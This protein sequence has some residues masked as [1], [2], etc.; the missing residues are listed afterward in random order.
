MPPRAPRDT[1]EIPAP[2]LEPLR[3]AAQPSPRD[4]GRIPVA[5]TEPLRKAAQPSPRDTGKIP[6]AFAQDLLKAAQRQHADDEITR[7]WNQLGGMPGAA[8]IPGDDGLVAVGIGFYREYQKG[9]IYYRSGKQPVHV[10]GAIGAKYTGLGGPSS[11]LGWPTAIPPPPGPN[12]ADPLTLPDEQPFTENGRVST[13]ENGAIYWWPDTGAIELGHI[14]VRYTGLACFGPTAG[15]SDNPYVYFGTVPAP[16]TAPPFST[17]TRI[18]D[19]VDEYESRED[20][21]ELYRGLPYG[22]TLHS[23]L[24]EHGSSDP[25]KYRDTIK[26]SVEQASNGAAAAVGYIPYVGPYLAPIAKAFLQAIGPDIV[27]VVEDVLDISEYHIGTE[28]QFISAKDMVT[29]T[30]APLNNWRGI[31]WNLGSPLISDDDASYRV[32]LAIQAA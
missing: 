5:A 8:T 11:W 9:R 3:K 31:L 28:T 15:G 12:A 30:R 13:F 16:G 7:R 26:T 6:G 29:L 27:E 10:Y 14:V 4:T 23:V 1:G 2:I 22:M 21:I 20:D 32:F 24:W 25:D 18:Y 19:G 17:R